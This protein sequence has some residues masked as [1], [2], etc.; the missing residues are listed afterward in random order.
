[1]K[2]KIGLLFVL[3]LAVV[4][5]S[6]M[7]MKADAATGWMNTCKPYQYTSVEEYLPTEMDSFKVGGREY[8]EGYVFYCWYQTSLSPWYS[9]GRTASCPWGSFARAFS[10]SSL[11]PSENAS[12]VVISGGNTRRKISWL[13]LFS[14]QERV[15]R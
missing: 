15:R 3:L 1:M 14:P 4:L 6:L 10:A 11:S 7:G 2:K 5:P 12:S 8:F 9:D 13:L